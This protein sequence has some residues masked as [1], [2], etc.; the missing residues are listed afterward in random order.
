MPN[1]EYTIF[2]PLIGLNAWLQKTQPQ[3]LDTLSNLGTTPSGSSDPY[4]SSSTL[5]NP[6]SQGLP[7]GVIL[8]GEI[9]QLI[10]HGKK[11][12]TDTTNGWL[13]GVDTD[14]VYKWLI[15]GSS[16][17]IDWSVTTEGVL[18]INGV[19][20]SGS[21]ITG[22]IHIPDEDTT[23]NS[24][25]VNTTGNTWWGTTES[26]FNSDN[27]NATAYVLSTGEARFADITITGTSD[28][29]LGTGSSILKANSTD[30]IWL[31][32][33]AFASALF[34][35]SLAGAIKSTSGVIGGWTLSA[36]QFSSA[37]AFIDSS[38]PSIGLGSVTDYFTGIGFWVGLS[39]AAYKLH[40]GD[41]DNDYLKWDGAN[42]EVTGTIIATTA[43]IS[44]TTTDTFTINSDLTDS[45][46]DLVFGRTTGGNA[47]MR[48]NGT[49]VTLDKLFEVP[50]STAGGSIRSTRTVSSSNVGGFLLAG[51][52]ASSAVTD[53][54]LIHGVV[55]VNTAGAEYGAFR[56]DTM[57]NGALTAKV[58]IEGTGD[59]GIGTT[60]P[61]YKLD[62][63]GRL[64]S[65]DSTNGGG[66][67]LGKSGDK[68]F[69]G[70]SST[71]TY[72]GIWDGDNW[73]MIIT[74]TTGLI[75]VNNL[76]PTARMDIIDTSEPLRLGYDVLNYVSFTVSSGGNLTVAPTGDFIF[77]PTGNDILPTTNYDLNLG[78][79]SKKYLTLHAAEL[80]VETLVAQNTIA[81]I[82]GRI[83]VGPTTTLTRDLTDV[84]T[85]IYVK[86]N[87]MASG[88]RA[89]ME[90]DGKVEFFAITSAATLEAEG[91]YSYTVTRNLDSSGANLWYAGDAMFNTGTTGDGFIDL[92]SINGVKAAS[93]AGPTIVGNVRNS[94]TYND[95]T[96]HW[97][98]GN[99]NGLYGY[100]VTTYGVAMGEYA[101]SKAHITIDSTNGFRIFTGTG[102]VVG[103]WNATGSITVGNTSTEHVAISSTAV[104]I[105][106]GSTIYTDLTAG[107][108]SLGDTSNEHTLIN[109]S[110][111]A[112]K[113][114]SN[115]YALFAAT[116]TIGLTASEHVSISSTAVQIKDG[117]TVYTDLTA[118]VLSL[119]DTSNEHVL[120]NT[121]GVS[122]KDS[123]NVY[124]V[125]AATTTIGLT[126]SEHVSISSTAVQIKDGS[127]VYTDLT[128]GVLTLG[129]VSGGEYVT[130]DGTNG[131]KM[132]GGATLNVDLTNAGVLTLGETANSKARTQISAGAISLISRSAGAVDTTV[133]NVTTAGV[134]TVGDT[135]VEHLSVSSTAV[136]IKD[137]AT[138]YTDLTAGA[139]S[140][141]DTSN[142]H[143]LVNTSGVALKDGSN[144]YGLFAATTT[145]GLTASEHV[146][147]SSTAVQIKDGSSVYTDLTAGVLT[148]GLTS[149][150]EY[151]T[152][153]G[154]N[155]IKMYGGAV[156]TISITNAGIVTVGEVGASKSNIQISSNQINLRTN[157][158]N[159]ITLD[160]SGNINI[161]GSLF[162]GT[163]GNIQSGQTAYNT[164]TGYFLEYNG[165][166]P[167]FSIGDSTTT[168]SLTWDGS[169]L[170]V[171]G[172]PVSN[173][174]IF[175]DGSDGDHTTAGNETLTADVYY[176]NLTIATGHTI[177]TAGF[178]IFVSGTLTFQG[179]GK[180]SAVGGA[181]GNGGNGNSSAQ[182][183]TAGVAGAIAHSTGTLP[184]GEDGKI[185][186]VGGGTGSGGACE[187]GG[188]GT[189]GDAA[190]KALSGAGSA[191]GEAG[192]GSN[193]CT[194]TGSAG[195]A[196]SVS[197]TVFNKIRNITSAFQLLDNFPSVT[198][199]SIAAGSGSGEGGASGRN[200]DNTTSGGGGGGG[201]SGATGGFVW[202]A[203]RNVVTVDG[204]TYA[205]AAGGVGG[206]GGNG[207]Q[208]AIGGG[209]TGDG[210]GGGGGAGGR[211]GVIVQI[212]SSLSG[213]GIASVAG[214]IGG[215]GGTAGGG[216]GTGGSNG[217]NGGTGLN[218]ALVV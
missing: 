19:L 149:G 163:S 92:Y 74:D 115:V 20:V 104:Q 124:G 200:G 24:F 102:T 208:G 212:Y 134:V 119:G 10:G 50:I 218:V 203:A 172:S 153:D 91:D 214:G 130:I 94:A 112:L 108:L 45:N 181:G 171:N 95:W 83:L 37:S 52:N 99:L 47:T 41:P 33:G 155:G 66:I 135:A 194:S 150:G 187:L 175:G 71:D 167:R 165:G 137:G 7:T 166:T 59:V 79:L 107:V 67:W 211:G 177:S 196:G 5:S 96:S 197:G 1:N 179:T 44:S 109:T 120:V 40:I 217:T 105:K 61:I 56:I 84:A 15:G 128:A 93:E 29:S 77:N 121:T 75:G 213:T 189:A 178:R 26:S 103:Q 136:Q 16:Y 72:T 81:T 140:L 62:V 34:S 207:G 110:G 164:G 182:G 68:S 100:G 113:D 4:N 18:T 30:G 132:Y 162:V 122:L 143:V 201:G 78:S 85:T 76:S 118:G 58:W 25:H 184:A 204:N 145:I 13:Q 73:A 11:T 199:F 60:N 138:V 195:S 48:W 8:S 3:P 168:N 206:N 87:E 54:A 90:A 215:T 98:I 114:G 69:L 180:L 191:G 46:V 183:G 89:Y 43:T 173:E 64:R 65:L 32:N 123:T 161:V 106:D 97:A 144:I 80:W 210:G 148:L 36:T 141:G 185:G 158:T 12:F 86:H 22:E 147:I 188:N 157:T 159:K 169:S 9:G 142:E 125:F 63:A 53:Y 88:D 28:V 129:L 23:A 38:V 21:I 160:T 176:S 216:G 57:T 151:T 131:I 17:S 126:A 2:D 42:L 198:V 205:T 186:G 193:G 82:G 170:L 35:V 55:E 139:L 70:R 31:G 174:T 209:S 39:S 111:V 192:N 190:T 156:E 6:L 127:T 152:I 202:F 27:T 117:S 14:G 51:Y 49:K 133:F 146:S 101:A 116:T 154:T